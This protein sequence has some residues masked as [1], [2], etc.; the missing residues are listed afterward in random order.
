MKTIRDL[1]KRAKYAAQKRNLLFYTNN[2]EKMFEVPTI[3]KNTR[4]AF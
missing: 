2:N 4:F 3:S 1:Q